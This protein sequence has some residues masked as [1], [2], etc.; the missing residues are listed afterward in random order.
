[1]LEVYGNSTKRIEEIEKANAYILR[2][3]REVRAELG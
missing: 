3:F 2:S 1:M